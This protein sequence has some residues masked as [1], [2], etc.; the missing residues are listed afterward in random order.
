MIAAAPSGSASRVRAAADELL[1]GA[2]ETSV[3]ALLARYEAALE[4]GDGD[5][6]Q[7]RALAEEFRSRIA[8]NVRF[9]P[10]PVAARPNGA[11]SAPIELDDEIPW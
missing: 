2:P 10:V 6:G 1:R 7:L 11:S 4:A 9:W 3:A 8:A 5:P